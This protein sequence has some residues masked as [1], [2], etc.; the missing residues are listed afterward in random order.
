MRR[1]AHRLR[2][3]AVIAAAMLVL[4]GCE[5]VAT[6]HPQ[7]EPGGTG[8]SDEQLTNNRY[9]VT[10]TGNSV[11]PRD[12]VEDY[13][14]LRSAEVTLHAGYHYFMFDTR[15]TKAKTTYHSDFVGWPGWPGYGW[16][17]HSWPYYGPGMMDADS[18]PVTR[19]YAYAEIV[20]LSDAQAANEPR[21]V[22]AEQVLK[23]IGPDIKAKP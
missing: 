22:E 19:Y 11:T 4:G 2:S 14:L 20:L 17:W 8:Y 10:F 6:Y 3:L 18:Y 15:D 23:H 21:A 1:S 7:T 12:T 9:R 13:L 16:Y 5:T